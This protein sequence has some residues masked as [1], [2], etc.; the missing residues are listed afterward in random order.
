[1]GQVTVSVNGRSH[2]IGCD[3]GDEDRVFEL[4]RYIDRRAGELSQSIGTASDSRILLM[5]ALLIADDLATAYEEIDRLRSGEAPESVPQHR[6][7][8]LADRLE[9][10]AARLDNS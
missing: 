9:A 2:T 7:A 5:T 6:A 3:D 8:D 4:A 10:I 1:M